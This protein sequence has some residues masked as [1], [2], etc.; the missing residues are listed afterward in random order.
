[1]SD[2]PTNVNP[3]D[4]PANGGSTPP[5]PPPIP[6][7]PPPPADAAYK[8][9][10]TPSSVAQNAQG[11]VPNTAQVGTVPMEWQDYSTGN[12]VLDTSIAGLLQTMGSNPE[13][14]LSFTRNA[15]EYGDLNL[16]DTTAIKSKYPQYE[17]AIK[18]MTQAV[19]AQNQQTVSDIKNTAYGIAGSKDNW[20]SAVRI[21]NA[22][23]PQYLRETVKTM[24]DN[25]H[26]QEGASMLMNAVQ[27]FG[28]L[29][30][31]MPQYSGNA[32]AVRGITFDEMKAE[33]AK[34]TAEA[35]GASLESGTY[36]RRYEDIMYR[37]SIGRAQGI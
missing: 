18:S 12:S 10:E 8:S 23:A 13:E 34:L 9:K 3:Q 6:P 28:S 35:G 36:G 33:L 24:I 30:Q 14:F 22:N 29:P 2:I 26:V 4:N 19:I 7:V 31:N 15:I 21:F 20:D 25:G 16:L 37:R 1:M 5:A 27:S 32:G 17:E 11:G